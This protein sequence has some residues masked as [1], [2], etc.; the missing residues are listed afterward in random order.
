M[1]RARTRTRPW[2]EV[3]CTRLPLSI[4][5]SCAKLRR[6]L[7]ESIGR[8]FADARAAIGQIAFMKMFQQPAV[9]QV[10]IEFRVG[11]TPGGSRQA[12]GNNRALPSGKAN[13]FGVE[14]RLIGAI[15]GDRPLQS[16]V[17]FEPFVVHAGEQ[18]RQRSDLIHH[19]GGMAIIPVGAQP[20]GDVLDNHPIGPAS[21]QRFETW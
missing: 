1:T 9:I 14:Q 12:R 17:A 6:D 21:R 20:V 16:L 13:P 3:S 7:D 11:L 2:R 18:R 5:R 4:P 15:G 8:L 19:L 10:Q